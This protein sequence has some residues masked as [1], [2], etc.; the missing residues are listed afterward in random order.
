MYEREFFLLE[1]NREGLSDKSKG[2]WERS[3]AD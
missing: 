3:D 2:K 1:K